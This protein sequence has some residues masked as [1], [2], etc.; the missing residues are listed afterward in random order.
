[1][2]RDSLELAN[3]VPRVPPASGWASALELRQGRDAFLSCQ[4]HRS[5]H[6]PG[7]GA[8]AAAGRGNCL[9]WL[10][11]PGQAA[12]RSNLRHSE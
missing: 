4:T 7:R 10:R 5:N 9:K 12:L 8:E 1:M 2:A 11:G 3:C 6:C